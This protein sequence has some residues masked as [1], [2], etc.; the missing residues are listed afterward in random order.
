VFSS[1]LARVVL[2]AVGRKV[3]LKVAVS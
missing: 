1:A 3:A 2:L